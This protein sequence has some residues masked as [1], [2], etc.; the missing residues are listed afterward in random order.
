MSF[1]LEITARC[2]NNCRHC[3]INLPAAD[4]HAR[5]NELSINQISDIAD[6][7]VA[8]GGLWCLISG[9]EPLLRKDFPD[10]YMML[11][12]KGLLVSVFTNACLVTPKTVALFKQFPPRDI[13]VSVY[14]ASAAI[15]EKVTRQ[16]GSYEAFRRGLDLLIAAGIKIRLKAMAMRSN[17]VALPDIAA[18]CR[19]HTKDY[20]RF[21]PLLHFRFDRNAARNSEILAERLTPEEIA[22]AEQSDGERVQ[23]LQKNC[24]T[25]IFPDR[26]HKDCAHIFHCGAGRNSFSVSP[27]GYFRLCSSLWH[28]NCVY[29]LKKGTLADAWERLAPQVLGMTS[30][31]PEFQQKCHNC[32]IVN[33]CLWCPANAYLETGRLDTWCEYFCQVAH[34]RAKALKKTIK[35]KKR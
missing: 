28:P 33:L 7:A 27:D 26:H 34:A 25:Y 29:D 23:A 13:E 35:Q 19:R 5:E 6:Q 31:N 21:D 14:G 32:S 4:S 18:F 20:F 12:K 24:D 16:P 15:Y 8:M 11:K 3:Y 22:M 9:G 17:I 1:E 30:D 10:I 2:N